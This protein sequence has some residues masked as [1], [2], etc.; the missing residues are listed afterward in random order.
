M[1]LVMDRMMLALACVFVALAG[2][3]GARSVRQGQRSRWT[4]VLMS[5][6][7][8]AQ[9]WALGERGQMRGQC[10]LGD[11]GEILLFLS[12]SAT[13]FY[14]VTGTAFRLS[15][16]GL[17]STPLILVAQ[18]FALI[19]GVMASEVERVPATDYWGELHMAVSVMAYGALALSAVAGVMVIVLDK[20]LKTGNSDHLLE[21]LPSISNLRTS[22]A[23]LALIGWVVLTVGIVAGL[24]ME[25]GEGV[26]HLVVA[27]VTWALYGVL[28]GMHYWRGIP[29]HAMAMGSISLFIFSLAVFAVL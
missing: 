10:P 27:S 3:A 8:G 21:T 4:L 26:A 11:A 23:R 6:A 25:G 15:L 16:L 12:W 9:C 1:G 19:P 14:L 22:L 24:M 5:L 7:F 13:L 2:I 29:P 28:I 18:L 20:K 17:F